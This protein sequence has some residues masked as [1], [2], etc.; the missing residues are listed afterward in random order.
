MLERNYN[1][2]LHRSGIEETL[3]RGFHV[4]EIYHRED[5]EKAKELVEAN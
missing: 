5:R 1:G 4:A 3:S 2:G